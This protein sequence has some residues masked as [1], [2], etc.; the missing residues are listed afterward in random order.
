MSFQ[1][2]PF[3]TQLKRTTESKNSKKKR[4]LPDDYGEACVHQLAAAVIG[5]KINL[6]REKT[7]Q[8]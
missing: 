6:G 7:A 4:L 8:L 3:G 2:E 1:S 5:L